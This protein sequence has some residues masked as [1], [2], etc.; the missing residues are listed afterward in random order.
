[1]ND[2]VG[3][4]WVAP[5]HEARVVLLPHA[6]AHPEAVVV[7]LAHAPSAVVAVLAAQARLPGPLTRVLCQLNLSTFE[8][9]QE[10]LT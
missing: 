3:V 5:P 4:M 2:V 6:G 1:M 7:E 8:I 10:V 9:Y